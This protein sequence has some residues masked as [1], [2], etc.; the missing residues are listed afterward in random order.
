MFCAPYCLL[1]AGDLGINKTDY[2]P[3]LQRLCLW[4]EDNEDCTA[5]QYNDRDAYISRT[6]KLNF[7]RQRILW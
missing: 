6:V 5:A 2:I 7:I 1:V 3:C 4:W